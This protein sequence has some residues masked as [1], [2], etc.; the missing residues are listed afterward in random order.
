MNEKKINSIY[1]LLAIYEDFVDPSKD[2]TL[3]DYLTYVNRLYVYWLGEGDEE[4]YNTLK[5]LWRLA[6]EVDHQTVKTAVFH[7][8]NRIETRGDVDGI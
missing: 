3:G 7:M 1:K 6:D 2:R 8:I 4:I 5:G